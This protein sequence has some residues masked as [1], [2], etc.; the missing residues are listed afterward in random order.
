MVFSKEFRHKFS[1]VIKKINSSNSDN[2]QMDINS[3][4]KT[5]KGEYNTI[6]YKLGKIL[7]D[8]KKDIP[9]A[10]GTP[11][12]LFELY[13]ENNRRKDNKNTKDHLFTKSLNEISEDSR[14]EL[15]YKKIEDFLEQSVDISNSSF[16]D[17]R[18]A[19]GIYPGK[20]IHILN[21]KKFFLIRAR[22]Y[23]YILN[24]KKYI[25]LILK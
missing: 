13:L 18:E 19:F 3:S 14:K 25:R 15:S 4:L 7:L 24:Q 6:S 8:S 10:L 22:V 21:Q 23:L 16:Q 11:K 9:S 17:F 12:K 2:N 5:S 1:N 20:Q